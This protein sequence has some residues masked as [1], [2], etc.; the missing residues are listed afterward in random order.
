MG[1]LYHGY[2]SHNQRAP[3][4]IQLGDGHCSAAS[5]AGAQKDCTWVL[6]EAAADLEPMF[7]D[8]LQRWALDNLD[9]QKK[10]TQNWYGIEFTDS[11]VDVIT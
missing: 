9:Q 5:R 8:V 3:H 11:L 6:E 4:R 1:H 2:V 7:L 10:T